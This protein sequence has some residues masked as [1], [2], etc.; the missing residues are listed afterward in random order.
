MCVCVILKGMRDSV[1]GLQKKMDEMYE[2]ENAKSNS[3]EENTKM[4]IDVICVDGNR[5]P[6][7]EQTNVCTELCI[8]G[9]LK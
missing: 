2:S 6:Q 9:N 5:D 1:T 8:K 4:V 3:K 7:F